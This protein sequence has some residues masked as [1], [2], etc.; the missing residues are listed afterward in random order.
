MNNQD[1]IPNPLVGNAATSELERTISGAVD[2]IW[3]TIH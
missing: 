3:K 2:A 1:L